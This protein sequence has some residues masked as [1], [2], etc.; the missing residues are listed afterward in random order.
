MHQK[1]N[2][3]SLIHQ[4]HHHAIPWTISG[5]LGLH[6]LPAPVGRHPGYPAQGV[7]VMWAVLFAMLVFFAVVRIA[8]YWLLRQ[9]SDDNG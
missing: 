6:V 7:Q 8:T 1:W 5:L 4:G 2:P 3:N 9:G